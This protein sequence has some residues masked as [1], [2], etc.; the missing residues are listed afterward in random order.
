MYLGFKLSM[1]LAIIFYGWIFATFL[2]GVAN[3]SRT[4]EEGEI[5]KG[6]NDEPNIKKQ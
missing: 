3:A 1:F 2:Y 4:D 5:F 6:F